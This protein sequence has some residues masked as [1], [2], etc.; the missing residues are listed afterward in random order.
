[1]GCCHS[2]FASRDEIRVVG[3]FESLVVPKPQPVDVV[4]VAP[5]GTDSDI[6]LFAPAPSDDDNIEISD[7]EILDDSD[8]NVVT[9]Q[10]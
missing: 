8:E 6:P 4:D 3:Q 10:D 5:E 1:M 9:K 7:V 2:L